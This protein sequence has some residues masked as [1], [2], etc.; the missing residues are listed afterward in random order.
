[1]KF[2]VHWAPFVN[3]W[4]PGWIAPVPA[5]EAAAGAIAMIASAQAPART[6][7]CDIPLPSVELVELRSRSRRPRV[8]LTQSQRGCHR[9][10]SLPLAFIG[11]DCANF[12]QRERDV[13]QAVEQAVLDVGI[14]VE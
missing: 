3:T 2:A 6:R 10:G 9:A 4:T 5:A 1:M 14:D 8:V 13:V 7:R 11:V 12:L